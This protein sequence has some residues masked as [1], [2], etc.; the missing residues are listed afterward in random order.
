MPGIAARQSASTIG[1][2]T[3][4]R[5]PVLIL[6]LHR[7][8]SRSNVPWVTIL[9]VL[10]NVFV[11]AFLQSGDARVYARAQAYYEQV[12]LG[13]LEFPAY[14]TWLN[15]HGRGA[16]P[17]DAH[18]DRPTGFMLAQMQSDRA[19]MADLHADK[20]IV[21]TDP[22]YAQWHDQR[23]Q[24]DDILDSAFTPRHALRFSHIEPGRMLT[25]M[26][27]H[28]GIEHLLGNMLFLLVIGMLVEG[29]LGAGWF[30][31]LYLLGGLLAA[32]TSL[33]WHWGEQ[34]A[35][36]GASG[37]IA[38]LMGAYCVIWGLRR[39]KVF[40]W[41]F[42]IFDYVKVPALVML[43]CWLVWLVIL[44]WLDAGTHVDYADHAGGLLAGTVMAWALRRHRRVRESFVEEDERVERQAHDDAE[45]ER[46]QDL[47]G[48]MEI[49]K[50]RE[51]FNRLDA[52]Q[53]GQLRVLIALYRCARYQG[54]STALDAAAARVFTLPA[55]ADGDAREQAQ[56]Y[57]DYAKACD[58][59]P[60][61]DAATLLGLLP[62]LQRAGQ[63]DCI[64]AIVRAL[65]G[66]E[67][68]NP[69]LP[70]A[71]FALCLRT[72][73]ASPARRERLRLLLDR[74]P[75]GEYAAKARFLLGAG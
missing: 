75:D 12:N 68:A 55:H 47:L 40:Y 14:V 36:L 50:A 8:W 69:A 16:Q 44:P 28:G 29:A 22:R 73:E 31:G 35:S 74:Y 30:F 2:A 61:L 60:R 11:Y 65:I 59:S 23:A 41:F 66:R 42:V 4:S 18:P 45:L 7:K 33:T 67:P 27:M 5:F 58:G 9:L 10:A 15:Q 21:P 38:A 24:F 19:F 70:V 25:A 48:R 54:Q 46:A 13:A 20:V 49:A 17:I 63:D 43:G 56:I 62:G 52:A 37:A 57:A 26:F 34:G 71:W 53:P 64:E 39:V 51:I 6:P 32:S 72:P 1:R 3:P